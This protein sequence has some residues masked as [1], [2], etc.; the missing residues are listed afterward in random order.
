MTV[1]VRVTKREAPTGTLERRI[2]AHDKK[3]DPILQALVN[4]HDDVRELRSEMKQ[5]RHDLPDIIARAVAPLLTR[6][7]D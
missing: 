4:V 5:L 3:F 6:R 2:A 7:E 1:E